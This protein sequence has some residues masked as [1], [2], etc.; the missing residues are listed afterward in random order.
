MMLEIGNGVIIKMKIV[1]VITVLL[2]IALCILGVSFFII[3]KA[4]KIVNKY[5]EDH[6]KWH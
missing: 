4:A 1:N 6:S 2:I 3:T 5:M